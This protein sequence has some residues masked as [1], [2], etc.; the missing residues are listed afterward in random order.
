MRGY[1][2]SSRTAVRVLRVPAGEYDAGTAPLVAS[3]FD[4]SANNILTKG[5][6]LPSQNPLQ[7]D[8]SPR[9]PVDSVGGRWGTE[10]GKD[11]LLVGF[12]IELGRL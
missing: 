10:Q 9:G 7:I 4:D 8:H 3:L 6:A 5:Q 12:L 11:R 2:R 1:W